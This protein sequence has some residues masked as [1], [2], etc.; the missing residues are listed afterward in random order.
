[1]PSFALRRIHASPNVYALLVI[2][3]GLIASLA[4]TSSLHSATD[5]HVSS[6]MDKE[7]Q[8][9][10]A[11]VTSG[12]R[13]YVDTGE[14]LAAAMGAQD[15]MTKDDFDAITLPLTEQQLPG[16]ASVNFVVAGDAAGVDA[17]ERKWREL[18]SRD[19]RIERTDSAEARYVVMARSLDGV[20]SSLGRD[21]GQIP[22]S[23]QAMNRARANKQTAGSESFVLL[24][25]RSL[26]VDR[27][28]SALVLSV[29]V[30]G[31]GTSSDAGQFRGWLNISLRADDFALAALSS[32]MD[33]DINVSI[34]ETNAAR[35]GEVITSMSNGKAL[36]DE[37]KNR[38]AIIDFAGQSW[39]LSVVPTE[40]LLRGS[41]YEEIV[42]FVI[43]AVISMLLGALVWVLSTGR[44]RA[45]KKVEE[46]TAELTADVK[47]REQV[48]EELRTFAAEAEERA[49][50]IHVLLDA[51]DVGVISC[52]VDGN[53]VFLN[54]MARRLLG[55]DSPTGT[56]PEQ[57]GERY[58]LLDGKTLEPLTPEQQPLLQALHGGT[59]ENE[60]LVVQL[61]S[62]EVRK[63]AVNGRALRRADGSTFG[64][65][66][67]GHDVTALTR[68]MDAKSELLREVEA[69]RSRYEDLLSGI[70]ELGE[71]VV[72]AE[73]E[74][75][76]FA[77][78]AISEMTGYT[79]Q[80]LLNLPSL[81]DAI[82]VKDRDAWRNRISEIEQRRVADEPRSISLVSKTGDEVPVEIVSKAL[83]IGDRVQRL[84]VIRDIRA[85]RQMEQMRENFFAAV[86]H[87]F[88]TPLTAV[89]GFVELTLDNDDT[90]PLADVRL[91]LDRASRA[92]IELNQ[93]VE[94]FL[95]FS[96]AT[97]MGVTL[98][99]SPASM[100]A[101]L[102]DVL[103][104]MAPVFH[105]H[106]VEQCLEDAKIAIDHPSF[107]RVI[108]NLMTN[109]VKY[110]PESSLI[111][112]RA[113]VEND[114]AR[115]Y[116][117]DRGS[118]IAPEHL[119]RIFDSYFR[120]EDVLG[121]VKGSGVG[122]AVVRQLVQ[123]MNGRVWA[124]NRD[125]GGS[126]F[127]VALPL[128]S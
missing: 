33:K 50:F 18:G 118:G 103:A 65:V 125:G 76:V 12:I 6:A 80:E 47:R 36:E 120:E 52:D 94:S 85:R 59:V 96:R 102:S 105:R 72:I 92:A 123:A 108:E 115:I 119:D 89:I 106:S 61:R 53:P 35:F 79:E 126:T 21:I 99:L 75:V 84:G 109:A 88:R 83:H 124:A 93:R 58:G 48:E 27:Q 104:Q 34:A 113:G 1:V 51:M 38:Q 122:L 69:Q 3:V 56:A 13:R 110:S 43:G 66:V 60:E 116:V 19:L 62:G 107:T 22:Q 95:D 97:R 41:A 24:R 11:D 81:L 57:W 70:S 111:E 14:S 29:P 9:T 82:H 121:S 10:A 73:G 2:A 64:A 71:G 67:V 49:E 90:T 40:G 112:V 26:P 101:A 55:I 87:D 68:E 42:T 15:H 63:L 45:L 25:D 127:C 32:A 17:L 44:S 117:E 128:A 39:T 78:H 5:D 23:V 91:F 46:A 28:Q 20:R 16:A 37:S 8:L 30:F 74:Q 100:K 31:A 114:E 77:N 54:G 4:A 98:E 86:S 7:L